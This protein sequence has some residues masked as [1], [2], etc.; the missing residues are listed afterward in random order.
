MLP[1]NS[2]WHPAILALAFGLLALFIGAGYLVFVPPLQVPD[3]FGH[4]FRAYEVSKGACL[5]DAQPSVPVRLAVTAARYRGHIEERRIVS[6]AA[7]WRETNE[8]NDEDTKVSTGYLA[9]SIYNCTPYL[10]ASLGLWI[11][12]QFH[13]SALT[14]MYAGRFANLLAFA[15]LSGL[16]IYLLPGYRLLLGAVAVMPMSLHQAASLS[17]DAVTT[18]TSFVLCAYILR[19]AFDP[20]QGPVRKHQ[21]VILAILTLLNASCR[22]NVFLML[23]LFLIPASKFAKR[24][25]QAA[26]LFAFLALSLCTAAVWTRVN[27][28]NLAGLEHQRLARDIEIR[29]NIGAISQHPFQF[30]GAVAGTLR[31]DGPQL[32]AEFVGRFGYLAVVLPRWAILLYLLLLLA[33]ALAEAEDVTPTLPQKLL[34]LLAV[35]ASFASLSALMWAFEAPRHLAAQLGQGALVP[36]LQGR[37]FISFCLLAFMLLSN[38]RWRIPPKLAAI[39][40][41]LVIGAVNLSA[42][43]AIWTTFYS[44]PPGDARLR[45]ANPDRRIFG[46]VDMPQSGS[47]VKGSCKVAGWA[48]ASGSTLKKVRIFIDERLDTEAA[49]GARRPDVEAAYPDEPGAAN[50]G[51]NVLLDLARL[52]PGG[53]MLSVQAES[54]LGDIAVIGSHIR[55]QV[56]K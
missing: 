55:I 46:I 13:A 49:L 3:E 20:R 24:T 8:P 53:H 6:L 12:R 39:P 30:A 51:F 43:G 52:R 11:A 22:F 33:L 44:P 23:L 9:A 27:Q 1:D 38:R 28:S 10:S 54:A 42:F 26:F 37:Y 47:V 5:A 50:S 56:E 34:L 31:H 48:I 18:A 21:L 35:T 19:L 41:L 17:V 14:E 16:A 45:K 2:G 25:Q 36:G 32:A 15:S 40:M 29:A 7:V 4:F